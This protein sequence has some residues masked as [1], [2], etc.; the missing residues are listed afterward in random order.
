MN[1]FCL[2]KNAN[3]KYDKVKIC[4]ND[5]QGTYKCGQWYTSIS[6]PL[7]VVSD[8]KSGIEKNELKK[9]INV[10][11]IISKWNHVTST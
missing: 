3:Q 10:V 8:E 11:A 1:V 9:L 7:K 6:L 2:L 4:C 5:M